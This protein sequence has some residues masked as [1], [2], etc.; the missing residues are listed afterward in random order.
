MEEHIIQGKAVNDRFKVD[1]SYVGEMNKKNEYPV[2]YITDGYWRRIDHKYIHYLSKLQKI[3]PVVI[4]GIGYPPGYDYGKIRER[5][6]LESPEKFL[7]LIKD[8]VIPFV[9]NKYSCD[10]SRRVL[11]GTS[12][13]GS[14]LVY[15]IVSGAI[16]Q[17]RTFSGFIGSSVVFNR[18]KAKALMGSLPGPG[19]SMPYNLYMSYGEDENDSYFGAPLAEFINILKKRNYK[20]LHFN[21]YVNPGKGH[22]TATRP[23]LV[24]GINL[25]L[26]NSG[27]GDFGF[28][29][30]SKEHL[31]YDFSAEVQIYDWFYTQSPANLAIHLLSFGNTMD[32]SGNETSSGSME[33]HC[34][35]SDQVPSGIVGSTFDPRENFMDNTFEYN[36]FIPDDLSKLGY[37]LQFYFP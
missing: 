6:F 2:V 21:Y 31:S 29:D 1:I 30:I 7:D 33:A 36:I 20:D 13:G 4:V 27:S 17:D 32:K 22:K 15:A 35:F 28:V 8:E 34:S 16:E 19:K 26:N 14:F 9:E 3:P 25:F 10:P 11:F 5:D 12:Y 18:S 23:T 24:D 37:T